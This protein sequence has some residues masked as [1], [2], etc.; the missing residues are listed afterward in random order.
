[1]KAGPGKSYFF[2]PKVSFLG[3]IIK[4]TTI[5]ALKSRIKTYL[6]LK[7]PINEKKFLVKL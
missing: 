3:H 7:P 2:L 5:T 6:K 4:A 1:M